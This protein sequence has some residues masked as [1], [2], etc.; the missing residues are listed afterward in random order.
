M[1]SFHQVL[2]GGYPDGGLVTDRKPL[3]LAD[4]AFSDLQNAYVWRERTKKREGTVGVGQLRRILTAA[5]LGTGIVYGVPFSIYAF[6]TPPITEPNA[7]II[8]GTV[9]IVYGGTTFTDQ[10]NGVLAQT[11][12]IT[13]ATQANP[14]QITSP[15]H[16]L[17]TGSTVTISGVGGM[18]QLNGNTYTITVT[19]ANTFTLNG[20]DSTGF[21]AYTS[22]GMWVS[23][24]VNN[25]GT[26]NYLTSFATIF[27]TTT[28]GTAATISFSYYPQL[29]VMGILKEDT[30]QLGI[31]NTIYFDTKYAYQYVVG[32]FQELVL[33]TTWTGTDTDFFWAANYQGVTPDERYFFVTNN[34]I[35]QAATPPTY[36][37]IRY[38]DGSAWTNLQPL[39]TA[40]T[41]LYQA[42]IIIPYYGRLLA[43]NTWEGLTSGGYLGAV[44]NYS[45]C[46]FS[47]IGNPIAADAWRYDMFGLG[48]FLD[49]PTNESIVSAAFHRNTLIVFFEYSTWQLR[50]IGEY[51]LP[52][53]FERI[54]SDFGSVSTYSP[55]VFDQ[56]I[57][58][59][60]DRGIIQAGA[61]GISRIDDQIPETVFSFEIQNNGPNFVHGIRDFEKEV[62]YWNY[63]DSSQSQNTQ[64]F[65]NATLLFN[66]RNNT[67]AQFRDNITCFGI[68]QFQFAI[69]WDSLTTYWESDASWDN[70]D[71]QAYVDYVTAGNQQGY[72][73]I[74]ENQDASTMVPAPTLFAPSL[75]IMGVNFSLSPTQFT[76]PNHNLLNGEIIYITGTLWTGTDPLINNIIYNVSVVDVNTLTLGL[77]DGTNY[78]AQS[79]VS[80]AVYLG[81][82]QITLFPKM[83]I[84]GKDFN[85]FQSAG[86]QFK[87]SFIDFQLDSNQASPAIPAITIQ[88]FVNS[89]VSQDSQANMLLG[90]FELLNSSQNAGY[91]SNAQ[92]TNPCIITSMN[93][94]LTTGTLI[95][96]GNVLGMVQL[97]MMGNFT[98]TV[99]DVNNFSLNGI[100][101]TGF[102]A[103]AGGG[104]WNS[105]P[106]NG[107]P[108]TSG[109]QYAWYRFY[110]T[111]YGQYLRI[112]LTYDDALMN[113]LAT[114][115]NPL[116]LNA[117]NCW[118]REG[119]RIVN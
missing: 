102:T 62:V 118:F 47:Q 79:F 7:V 84:V 6:L 114:H 8:P 71:D 30:S 64:N 21:G 35:H 34:N 82:G 15:A 112:A 40:T 74:Y 99:I 105:S 89:Y 50:Y 49:A 80:S 90:N 46:N 52:F 28:P 38:Y 27:S 106:T 107:Q 16:H 22:G 14:C 75:T 115:Q 60:S 23:I 111:Q 69:T 95:A 56:G 19:G 76:V 44:N 88:L 97:N 104:I 3:M 92:Q 108:Y 1:S 117:M 55:I 11:G 119:G 43:L 73:F 20:V 41:T 2:I 33:G 17:F 51:G 85:P 59:V 61:A 36:D 31:D 10:G 18:T 26:I 81:G 13:G 77:W 96:I 101:A 65:P 25:Y 116:E 48:G 54:S 87:L 83:N 66:Y 113:Q 29:P 91:I 45:R 72:I 93:H 94:S 67:W 32:G 42:L 39:T 24:N 37:P 63:L 110:S 58:T 4:Q 53:I 86:K 5:S 109:S 9:V 57:M 12:A 100:D 103:Y 78:V 70:V 68:G 98:V